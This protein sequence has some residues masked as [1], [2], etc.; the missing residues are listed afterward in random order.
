M[1]RIAL[2]VAGLLAVVSPELP[3]QSLPK[4]KAPKVKTPKVKDPLKAAE[5]S[6]DAALTGDTKTMKKIVAH[7]VSYALDRYNLKGKV[8]KADI[9]RARDELYE[10]LQWKLG[11]PTAV[12][13]QYATAGYAHFDK[14]Y[15]DEAGAA[16]LGFELPKEKGGQAEFIIPPALL[17]L[18]LAIQKAAIPIASQALQ[19]TYGIPTFISS[20]VLNAYVETEAKM[21]RRVG[22]NIPHEYDFPNGLIRMAL[23]ARQDPAGTRSRLQKLIDQKVAAK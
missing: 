13:A 20:M 10:F 3:A 14:A 19:Q 6:V 23:D 1:K 11:N 7:T 12:A 4:V 18:R 9:E 22:I 16:L 2:L 15:S 8:T 17:Q 5:R 21:L